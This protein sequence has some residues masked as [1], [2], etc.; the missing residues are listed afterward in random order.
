MDISLQNKFLQLIDS[1]IKSRLVV[2]LKHKGTWRTVEP[3]MAGIH[4]QKQTASLYC[5]CRDVIPGQ[6]LGNTRWQIFNLDDIEDMEL[7][8]YGFE[9]HIDYRGKAESFKPVYAKMAA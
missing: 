7:T 6:Q 1:A 9:T 3:Y 8:L 5:Y 2:Q 4:Q